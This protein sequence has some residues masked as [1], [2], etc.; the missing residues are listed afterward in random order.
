MCGV[1]GILCSEYKKDLEQTA[2]NMTKT[3]YHRGPDDSGLW[4]NDSAGVALGHRRLS[5]LDLSSAGHQPMESPDGRYVLVFNG[6]IYNHKDIR[7][8]LDD[9][10]ERQADNSSQWHGHS[11][12]E[13]LLVCFQNWGI[14]QTLN[15]LV[16]MFALALWDK[17]K[18]MLHLARDRMGE[19]PLYYGWVAGAFVFGSELKSLKAYQG[20]N[21][22]ISREA[23]AL[24]LQYNYVP[25]PYSIYENIYKLEPGC[26]LSLT[27]DAAAA[28]LTSAP[29]VGGQY[30]G[31]ILHEWWSLGETIRRKPKHLIQNEDEAVDGLDRRL[32]ESIRLQSI[33]DVPL[34]A[35]LSG[36]IDSSAVVALMQ[37]EA[38]SPVKTFTIGF[39]ESEYNEAA[40]AKKVARYLGTEHTELYLSPYDVMGVIPRLPELYDEPF[41]DSSQIPTFLISQMARLHVTVALSG[42]GGDE[43]FGGYNRYVWSRRIWKSFSWLPFVARHRLGQLL[44]SQPVERIDHLAK[45]LM[46]FTFCNG[47]SLLSEK[48]H[49]VAELLLLAENIDDLYR[50][51]ITTWKSPLPVMREKTGDLSARMSTLPE[52]SSIEDRMMYLDAMSYLPDDILCK[53]DRAAMGVGLESRTPFLDHRVVEYAWQIPLSMKIKNGQGK[54]LLRQLLFKHVPK[55]LTERPK[56]G[57]A[58]PL[59][60][61]LR[62]PLRDWAEELLDEHRLRQ[63]GYFDPE[64]IRHKWHEHL[65]GHGN[66]QHHLWSVLMFQTWLEVQS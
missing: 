48:V 28:T 31:L 45:F 40:S 8:E 32:R 65:A 30:K 56:Q 24:Y 6:E 10:S 59:A 12:T 14:K 37:S 64:L 66:W 38:I 17:E 62:G 23:L 47:V 35:F 18:K 53:L 49:K 52:F 26:C 22:V 9:G 25:S 1:T 21:N 13:T 4:V 55:E 3:M 41:A 57:F 11:D 15:R 63:E 5:I 39:S 54:W 58:I 27:V 42:D 36:G 34:G 2:R 19:K 44:L 33:A 20:F 61:W 29:V 43:L 46:R 60:D 16:G 51:V 7:R 50:S